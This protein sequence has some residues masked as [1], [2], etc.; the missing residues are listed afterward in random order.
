MTYQLPVFPVDAPDSLEE[1]PDPITLLRKGAALVLSVSGG[2]DSEAEC[3]EFAIIE[4]LQVLQIVE[5]NLMNE[6]VPINHKTV[7]FTKHARERLDLRRI[8][9]R[10]SVV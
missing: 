6:K 9:D 8:G 5:R 3:T 1:T 10:K 4:R 7:V 2:K